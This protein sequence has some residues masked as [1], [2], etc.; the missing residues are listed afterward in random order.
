MDFRPAAEADLAELVRVQEEASVV[1]LAHVFPQT[2][3]PFPR[4]EIL[5]RW[6]G[7]LADP[8][9]ATYVSTDPAGR[10]TGFAA[11]RHDELL[12]FGT[13]IGTWGTGLAGALHDAL[14]HT[15]PQDR[16]RLW[17]LVFEENHR[18][19]RFWEKHGWRPT[20][21]TT[22]TVFAPHPVLAEY[23]LQRSTRLR[24]RP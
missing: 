2:T 11:R 1:A 10:L 9:V 7:E 14:L 21:R 20:G 13:A 24:P 4:E 19:R 12:H 17:L 23:E 3:H 16:D 18:A 6:R 22:R 5:Q 15:F 8:D